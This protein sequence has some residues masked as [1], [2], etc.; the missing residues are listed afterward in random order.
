[1]LPSRLPLLLHTTPDRIPPSPIPL[2]QHSIRQNWFAINEGRRRKGPCAPYRGGNK[3]TSQ[4]YA[5]DRCVI[6]LSS[7]SIVPQ[8]YMYITC[9]RTSLVNENDTPWLRV[10]RC[11]SGNGN[12]QWNIPLGSLSPSHH[13]NH[14]ETVLLHN[15]PF[16]SL[17]AHTTALFSITSR[18]TS[19]P[20]KAPLLPIDSLSVALL[21][22][23]SLTRCILLSLV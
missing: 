20:N 19:H 11:V 5:G 17:L 16:P 3:T 22:H 12:H 2:W 23:S 4:N 9:S 7:L 13:Q 10:S 18:I 21:H 15:R 6:S 8:N 1:M 14:R